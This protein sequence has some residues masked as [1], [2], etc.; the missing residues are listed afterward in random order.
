[1]IFVMNGT[2]LEPVPPDAPVSHFDLLFLSQFNRYKV[3][4]LIKRGY[5]I[6]NFLIK[7]W[8]RNLHWYLRYIVS[9]KI[10]FLLF[11]DT[12]LCIA[13]EPLNIPNICLFQMKERH[14]SHRNTLVFIWNFLFYGTKLTFSVKSTDFHLIFFLLKTRPG[15]SWCD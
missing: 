3:E 8:T 15:R 10:S 11:V 14:K 2:P 12:F 13:Q 7:C 9:R 4:S 6:Q 1:M 5:R